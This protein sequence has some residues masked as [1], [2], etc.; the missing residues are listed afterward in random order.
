MKI[1]N[2]LVFTR[3]DFIGPSSRLRFI[4]YFKFLEKTGIK[5]IH[6]PLFNDKYLKRSFNNKSIFAQVFLGYVTRFFKLLTLSKYDIIWVEKELFPYL[7]YFVENIFLKK[8]IT[9][10]VD[11]DDAIFD[12]YDSSRNGIFNSI[13]NLKIAKIMRNAS[14]VIVGNKYLKNYAL[15]VA[16]AK[17]I[18]ELPTVVNLDLYPKVNHVSNKKFIKVGWIGTPNTIVF[19]KPLFSL[20]EKL[21]KVL[22]V[23]FVAIGVDSN[24]VEHPLIKTKKWSYKNEASLL[25]DIDIGLM[26]LPNNKWTKGKCGYKLIQ[27]MACS[28]PVI[29]SP[30]GI[31]KELINPGENG[32]LAY[33]LKDWGRYLRMLINSKNLRYSMGVN[34]RKI[35]EKKY[36]I[37]ETAP[38]LS[39][40]LLNVY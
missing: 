30:I 5:I 10:I 21:S 22:D 38:K 3:Y 37:G 11:Y 29:A 26:P 19:L 32:Y 7:P 20:F 17:K 25:Q 16:K 35:V 4:Q 2:V 34:G 39:E 13:F 23:E 12:N 1:K 33:D 6:S 18:I 9:Y 28:K 31:N 24:H 8:S 15:N 36:S 27:Y 14:V 40:I